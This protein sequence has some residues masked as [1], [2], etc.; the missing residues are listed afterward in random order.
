MRG[1]MGRAK[2]GL[3][4]VGLAL[5]ITGCGGGG[6]TTQPKDVGPTPDSDVGVDVPDTEPD[7]GP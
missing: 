4:V 5:A 3:I 6:G 7:I 2:L 1:F